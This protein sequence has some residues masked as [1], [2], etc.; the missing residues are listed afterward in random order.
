MAASVFRDALLQKPRT[1]FKRGAMRRFWRMTVICMVLGL[2]LGY[3]FSCSKPTKPEEPKGVRLYVVEGWTNNIYVFDPQS[4]ELLDSLDADYTLLMALSPD[5]QY[6]FTTHDAPPA[7]GR[8]VM[9]KVQTETLEIVG[10]MPKIGEM[11][12]LEQGEILLRQGSGGL[13]FIDPISFQVTRVDSIALG[14]LASADTVGFILGV[15]SWGQLTAYDFRNKQVLDADSIYLSDG[16]MVR[17]A[18]LALHPSGKN[19]FGIFRDSYQRSWFIDFTTPNLEIKYVY[20]LFLYF[21]D[22]VEA[23]DGRYVIFNDPGDVWHGYRED[24]LYIYD[25]AG[26]QMLRIFDLDT[27]SVM[28]EYPDAYPNSVGFSPD[29]ATAYFGLAYGP[30]LVYDMKSLEFIDQ[31][32][33][34]FDDWAPGS[35][36]VG[37]KP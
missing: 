4:K 10:E 18:V 31:I 11:V 7:P 16:A 8:Q 26:Q 34:A 35:F 1:F 23:P 9:K 21:G 14:G 17:A 25:V 3:A 27:L 28:Q 22:M 20:Q 29:G 37:Y 32:Q 6:L 2:G 15:N 19:G 33:P 36:V 24:K 5:G 30:I 13:E 12:F